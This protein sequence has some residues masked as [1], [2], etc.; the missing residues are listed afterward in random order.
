MKHI[1]T[2]VIIALLFAGCNGSK[3]FAKLG[4]KQ[5]AAG[6]TTEAAN[7][8]Y[9]SLL[10]KRNN[11]DAQIGMKKT[12]QLVLN[13]KL[14]EF[15]KQRNFGL[16]KQAVYAYLDA[17]AYRDKIQ[18]VGITLQIAEFYEMDYRQVKETYLS[19]LYDQ[20]LELME[21]EE[22]QKAES[23]LAEIKRLDPEY[24]DAKEL[25]DIAYLEPLYASAVSAYEVQ[26]YREAYNLFDQVTARRKDYKKA[27]EL[28]QASLDK[29]RYT[30]AI[31]PFDNTTA[32]RG[33]ESKVGAYALQALTSVKDPFLRV[34]DRDNMEAILQEQKLQLSA[35]MDQATAVQAGELVGADAILTGTVLSFTSQTGT[36]RSKSRPVYE[37]F[38][39]KKLNPEDGKFYMEPNYRHTNY[40]EF[41]NSS[42]VSIVFQ[43]K[44]V[45]LKTGEIIKTN[46]LTK[47][48]TDEVL[49]GKYEGDINNLY[50]AAGSAPS[51]K[52]ADRRALMNILNGR[53]SLQNTSQ[54]SESLFNEVSEEIKTDLSTMLGQ[55]VP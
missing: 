32:Q 28:K 26:H 34:V 19:Q 33:I 37:A 35:L 55:L 50:P 20:A 6:L 42:S 43:Y 44:L 36:L 2:L 14:S 9:T 10:K 15:A 52:A 45:S 7:S 23:P 48:V 16:P 13:T 31:L 5:E 1:A 22:F 27:R 47:D 41:Y 30:V 39:V 3:H 51:M 29:G 18:H 17:V 12:G 11:L 24:K 21:N 40:T 38:M 4:A 54:L 25:G 8:Y 53:Q 49:Y 46:I